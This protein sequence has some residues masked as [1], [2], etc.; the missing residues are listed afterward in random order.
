MEKLLSNYGV[1]KRLGV[2]PDYILK[3]CKESPEQIPKFFL[4]HQLKRWKESDVE[5]WLA[6]QDKE[7]GQRE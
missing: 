1:A 4:L 6:E 3:C 2:S 7:N 5:E